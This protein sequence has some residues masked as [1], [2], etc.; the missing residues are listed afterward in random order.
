MANF[1]I[2]DLQLIVDLNFFYEIYLIVLKNK[3]ETHKT[4]TIDYKPSFKMTDLKYSAYCSGVFSTGATGAIAPVILRK[5]LIAPTVSTRNGK[6]LLA[7]STLNIK[8][9]NTPLYW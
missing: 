4:S 2:D 8:I 6:I 1:L 9:L 5:R 7:L 3:L